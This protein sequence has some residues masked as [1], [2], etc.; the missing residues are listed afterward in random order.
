MSGLPIDS[1]K[2]GRPLESMQITC[3][4]RSLS[5]LKSLLREALI[6]R[7]LVCISPDRTERCDNPATGIFFQDASE[8]YPCCDDHWPSGSQW[9]GH[10]RFYGYVTKIQVFAERADNID[11]S[12]VKVILP[13]DTVGDLLIAKREM[14]DRKDA[15]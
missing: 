2:V 6:A 12:R 10:T 8:W 13:D 15:V 3:R 4:L 11:F 5:E 1:V 7:A 14:Y 9:T